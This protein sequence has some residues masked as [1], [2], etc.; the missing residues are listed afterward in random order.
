MYVLAGSPRGESRIDMTVVLRHTMARDKPIPIILRCVCIPWVPREL[1]LLF[2]FLLVV[3]KQHVIGVRRAVLPTYYYWYPDV[4]VGRSACFE[5][6][7]RP[8][9]LLQTQYNLDYLGIDLDPSILFYASF[10]LF[11]ISSP[12]ADD[13]GLT[14]P[15]RKR[16]TRRKANAKIT[17]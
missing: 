13:I 9:L 14:P 7:K 5:Y 15:E 17:S 2:V 1:V 3:A 16:K 6:T 8:L 11:P 12:R 4:E 10:S